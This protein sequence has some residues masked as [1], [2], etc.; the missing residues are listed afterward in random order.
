M[1]IQGYMTVIIQVLNTKSTFS[2]SYTF[3]SQGYRLHFDI[4]CVVFFSFKLFHKTV[5]CKVQFSRLLSLSGNDKRCTCFINKNGVHFI[6]NTE[7]KR[8]L[9]H[10]FFIKHHVV[11]QIIETKFVVRAIRNIA[12]VSILFISMVHTA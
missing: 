8:A 1:V 10:L 9:N 2:S 4:N 7:I 12:G 3:F 11:T 5:C 6:N